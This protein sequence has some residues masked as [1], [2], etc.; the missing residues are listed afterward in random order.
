MKPVPNPWRGDWKSRLEAKLNS[1]GFECLE[2]FLDANPGV[3]Y[4]RMAKMLTE[5]DVAALQLY[6]EHIRNA[7]ARNR[8]RE[9]ARDSLVRFLVEHLKYGWG[10]GRHFDFHWA[11]AVAAWKSCI[12]QFGSKDQHIVASL[13]AVI[14]AL[15]E[16]APPTGWIPQSPSDEYIETAFERGWPVY[17]KN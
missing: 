1:M 9:A 13:D 14:N 4:L 12:V 17:S 10:Q 2:Q 15:K 8:L 5:A 11:S 3:D 7:T 6:G 16:A